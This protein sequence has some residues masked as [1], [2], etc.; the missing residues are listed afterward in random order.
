[1]PQTWP[2]SLPQSFSPGVQESAQDGVLRTEMDA[3]P[4][5]VRRRYSAVATM[6]QGAMILTTAQVATLEAF[7][8]TTLAG[9]SDTINW[10]HPRTGGSAEL[11]F[12]SPPQYQAADAAKRY[13]RANLS[14]EILP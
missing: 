9:G 7:Y 6:F 12:V 8:R 14:L 4:A 11:R 13:W 1:M 3:G 10:D 2:A 5:F